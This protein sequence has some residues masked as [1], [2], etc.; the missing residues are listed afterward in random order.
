MHK[1]SLKDWVILLTIIPT[2]LIGLGIASYFSFSRYAELDNFLSSQAQSIIE[3][4]AI[5]STDHLL[6]GQREKLR[7]LISFSHRSQSSIV[8]SIALFTRDNQIFVTSSYHGDVN[9]MRLSAGEVIPEKTS[10]QETTL[11]TPTE[12]MFGETENSN[13]NNKQ[14]KLQIDDIKA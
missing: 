7:H 8:K 3:P 10:K 4:L 13:N 6:N 14:W 1:I 11:H 12:E 2:T 5:A 9:L